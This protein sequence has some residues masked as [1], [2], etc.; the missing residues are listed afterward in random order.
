VLNTNTLTVTLT[1]DISPRAVGRLTRC[2]LR[3][4]ADEYRGHPP[5]T[6][7]FVRGAGTIGD[8]L[9]VEFAVRPAGHPPAYPRVSFAE[10]FGPHEEPPQRAISDGGSRDD[11]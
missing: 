5:G 3:A 10:L 8:R 1:R 6:L 2:R 11:R 7:L 9:A 4:N